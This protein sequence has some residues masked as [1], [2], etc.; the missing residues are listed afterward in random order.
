MTT[1]PDVLLF[2]GLAIA[3][4]GSSLT[5]TYV[6][7][8]PSFLSDAGAAFAQALN[9]PRARVYATNVSDALTGAFVPLGA[10]R[11]R[12]A[13]AGSAGVVITFVVRLGKTP[14]ACP[15]PRAAAGWGALRR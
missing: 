1:V 14:R 9:L 8:L 3:P 6:A 2:F 15:R 11:R 12:L 5:A 10:I 13:G 7:S 4:V